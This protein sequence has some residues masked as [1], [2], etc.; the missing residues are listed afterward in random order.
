M[1]AGRAIN[2]TYCCRAVLP[3]NAAAAT[4]SPATSGVLCDQA[5]TGNYKLSH[6]RLLLARNS[7]FWSVR[8]VHT[9]LPGWMSCILPQAAD[10][11]KL[12]EM[13]FERGCS[14]LISCLL[15]QRRCLLI[16]RVIWLLLAWPMDFL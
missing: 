10:Y 6:M 3:T 15:A 9:I 7:S 8:A 2:F 11:K 4:L 5:Q 13:L 12:V 1:R 14:A 16:S